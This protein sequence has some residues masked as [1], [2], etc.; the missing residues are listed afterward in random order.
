MSEGNVEERQFIYTFFRNM[1]VTLVFSITQSRKQLCDGFLDVAG[2]GCVLLCC[3][4]INLLKM[5]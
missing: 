1:I 2:D 3:C 4:V 5:C